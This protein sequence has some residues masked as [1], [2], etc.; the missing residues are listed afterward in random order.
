MKT[1][2]ASSGRLIESLRVKHGARSRTMK[3]GESTSSRPGPEAFDFSDHPDLRRFEMMEKAVNAL[4]MQSPF[5]RLHESSPGPDQRVSGVDVVN[6]ASYDY[7]GLNQAPEVLA[8]AQSTLANTGI[9]PGASR[10]V[11]GERLS[12]QRLEVRLAENYSAEAAVAMV[13]GHATN[14]TTIGTLLEPEDLILTDQLA[15]NSIFE[16][17]RLSGANRVSFPHNDFD[18]LERYLSQSR[19]RYRNVM[20]AVEGLYSMDGDM[21]DLARLIDIK[22]RHDCWLM[23]DEAHALGVLGLTGRGTAEAQ[24]VDPR[25]VEIWMGTLSK[26]LGS[27]GGYIAGSAA[28]VKL[29]KHR[30]PGFVFSVG[31]SPVLA[32]GAEAALRLMRAAPDRVSRLQQN[33]RV[34][35]DALKGHGLDMGSAQGYAVA[36][37]ITGDSVKAVALSSA[38]FDQGINALPVIY[39]AVPEKA[40][41]VRFFVTSEHDASQLIEIAQK[42]AAC[43]TAL[44]EGMVGVSQ[45]V[46]E[47][48]SMLKSQASGSILDLKP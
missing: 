9:S 19:H 23:V 44:E 22:K 41:R 12:Q 36:P 39:P 35:L 25:Q 6:F 28:L 38:L 20:I 11:G 42:I 21:P 2:S 31:L 16:G 34:F 32:A 48:A 18:W 37:V 26:T 29:L 13:S 43:M 7:L 3:E 15:H 14:V 33:G 24:D 10:L 46:S 4:G 1:G 47:I 27:C 30:A 45:Q 17:A 8:A 5:F 40:A